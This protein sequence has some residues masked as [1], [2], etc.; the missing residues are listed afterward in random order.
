MA[1]SGRLLLRTER[2]VPR[3]IAR[4]AD[5]ER[6]EVG[7]RL[8]A[9]KLAL[10]PA[11]VL[12]LC[13]HGARVSRDDLLAS[14]THLQG[15]G[16]R[17]HKATIVRILPLGHGRRVEDFNVGRGHLHWQVGEALRVRVHASCHGRRGQ[18]LR[19]GSGLLSVLPFD[20]L[21]QVGDVLEHLGN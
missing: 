2:A 5:V 18:S 4:Q 12:W 10:M 19:L 14:R 17:H 6:D 11:V 16:L 13:R 9:P 3:I 8:L 15:C 7:K 21:D 1:R 20:D